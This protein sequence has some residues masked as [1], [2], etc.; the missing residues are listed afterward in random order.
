MRATEFDQPVYAS[1]TVITASY[2]EMLVLT[3]KQLW[4]VTGNIRTVSMCLQAAVAEGAE[5]R[6]ERGEAKISAIR[7]GSQPCA[8]QLGR[9]TESSWLRRKPR[10]PSKEELSTPES[11]TDADRHAVSPQI[12]GAD[13]LSA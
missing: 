11:V 2:C 8:A 3:Q 7:R 1:A 5:E 4:R 13:F 10:S 6:N 9:L 12:I